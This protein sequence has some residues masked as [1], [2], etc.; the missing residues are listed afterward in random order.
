[1]PN[2]SALCADISTDLVRCSGT[3]NRD[4]CVLHLRSH[5]GTRRLICGICTCLNGD[6][7]HFEDPGIRREIGNLR[8][9]DPDVLGPEVLA[10][11][12]TPLRR[13]PIDSSPS[14]AA[15]LS[16]VDTPGVVGD[17]R[18]ASPSPPQAPTERDQVDSDCPVARARDLEA[19]GYTVTWEYDR[20]GRTVL[21]NDCI[22]AC[23]RATAGRCSRDRFSHSGASI[24]EIGLK[25]NRR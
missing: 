10:A 20:N 18:L 23:G 6:W 13:E 4:L 19:Q 7:L 9:M 16:R 2:T 11:Q 21:P 24:T 3:C 17:A 1:M 14:A 15:G 22:A 25:K 5:L 12:G 8:R